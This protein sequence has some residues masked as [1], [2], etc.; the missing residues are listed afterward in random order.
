[1]SK[2]TAFTRYINDVLKGRVKEMS[3]YLELEKQDI[4]NAHIRGNESY[5]DP[6]TYIADAENYYNE[7]YKNKNNV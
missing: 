5:L 6:F 3:Y 4:I 2:Q 7:T 1:M